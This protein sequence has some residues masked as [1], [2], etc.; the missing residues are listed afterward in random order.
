MSAG[1]RAKAFTYQINLEQAVKTTDGTDEEE[2]GLVRAFTGRVN[3][4]KPL[5]L[6]HVGHYPCDPVKPA[7]LACLVG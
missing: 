2:V 3:E 5:D 6:F 4:N 1:P 7:K